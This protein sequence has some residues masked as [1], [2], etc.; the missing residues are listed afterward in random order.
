M[1]FLTAKYTRNRYSCNVSII[2]GNP[3]MRDNVTSCENA[4]SIKCGAFKIALISI[5]TTSNFGIELI[6]ECSAH[7]ECNVN[8]TVNECVHVHYWCKIG[9]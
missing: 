6:N 5:N 7:H 2:S 1:Y 9:K 4:M 8:N 3:V